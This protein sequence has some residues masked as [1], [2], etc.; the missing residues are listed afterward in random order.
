MVPGP[1]RLV[2]RWPGPSRSRRRVVATGHEVRLDLAVGV[3]LG[4]LLLAGDGVRVG[5]LLGDVREP[6]VQVL[7]GHAHDQG[8]RVDELLGHEARVRVDALAH[9]VA[10]HVL[11]TAGDR[12]RRTRRRRCRRRVW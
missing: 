10:A 6:V 7:G 5:A 9:R 11:D 12:R 4:G 1:R 8:G 2:A 3:R